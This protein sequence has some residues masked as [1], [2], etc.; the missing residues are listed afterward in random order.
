M[1]KNQ[2]FESIKLKEEEIKNEFNNNERIYKLIKIEEC[3]LGIIFQF[4]MTINTLITKETYNELIKRI[5]I[6]L[7]KTLDL[8]DE[9]EAEIFEEHH[10]FVSS[11][12][13]PKLYKNILE[14]ILEKK[15]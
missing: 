11:D 8:K 13:D 3:F 1:K 2:L 9:L 12:T 4:K 15:D 10:R 5:T 7:N 6:S 14:I